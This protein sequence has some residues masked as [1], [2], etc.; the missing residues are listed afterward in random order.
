MSQ[1]KLLRYI[2]K[3][4]RHSKVCL[5]WS[6]KV[7]SIDSDF[8]SNATLKKSILDVDP[9]VDF[10]FVPDC[11]WAS[12]PCHTYSNLGIRAH[13]SLGR[14]EYTISAEAHLH[15]KIFLKLMHLLLWIKRR[16]PHVIVVIENPVGSLRK[17]PLM[18]ELER[19]LG[20]IR[21]RVDYCT[22]GREEKKPTMLW[23][24]D[25]SL[26]SRLSRYNC[27][28]MCPYGNSE[29]GHPVD[30][31]QSLSQFDF[32]A[33][34]EALAEEVAEY[35]DSKFCLDNLRQSKTVPPK[36]PEKPHDDDDDALLERD[37]EA[38]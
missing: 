7:Q 28:E 6:E 31:Q 9:S 33:I 20:L 10:D 12:P 34:P 11:V 1:C 24:N 37:D 25:H 35:V 2:R 29:N 30:L 14:G 22:F 23:T 19:E 3:P 17:M 36:K 38:V 8:H 26:R 13:R 16:H 18:N 4:T 27:S 5:L 15:D 32:S 21:A